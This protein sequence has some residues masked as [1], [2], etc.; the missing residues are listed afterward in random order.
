MIFRYSLGCHLEHV[1]VAENVLPATFRMRLGG[2][3][4][5]DKARFRDDLPKSI[6]VMRNVMATLQPSGPASSAYRNVASSFFCGAHTP[7]AKMEPPLGLTSQSGSLRIHRL[8][9]AVFIGQTE[10]CKGSHSHKICIVSFTMLDSRHSQPAHIPLRPPLD[11]DVLRLRL[12]GV[13]SGE[14]LTSR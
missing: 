2:S 3:K 5:L 12:Y 8:T 13:L 7:A 1:F 11:I 6:R 14:N 9:R 4:E 10:H